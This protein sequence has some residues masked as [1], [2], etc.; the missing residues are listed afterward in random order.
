[1]KPE[2]RKFDKETPCSKIEIFD[3]FWGKRGWLARQVY[4]VEAEIGR[5]VP[6]HLVNC[7]RLQIAARG[8]CDVY[9]LTE[10]GKRWLR[11]GIVR[12]LSNN[13]Y[14]IPEI[15]ERLP[16]SIRREINCE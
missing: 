6:R 4:E 16:L 9:E 3:C 8:T 5:H 12:Y 13:R 10:Q 11:E 7:N 2:A 14:R 15:R 1:M